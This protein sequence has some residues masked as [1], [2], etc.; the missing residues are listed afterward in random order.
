MDHDHGMKR[1]PHEIGMKRFPHE[2]GMKRFP[3]ENGKGLTRVPHEN[4][5]NFS[6]MARRALIMVSTWRRRLLTEGS[7]RP[8]VSQMASKSR[9]A[10]RL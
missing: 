2:N 8:D 7:G 3:R 1:F 10:N 6:Q 5:M 4:G 9:M